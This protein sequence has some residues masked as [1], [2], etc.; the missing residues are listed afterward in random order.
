VI[1]A[2]LRKLR[3]AA[4][5]RAFVSG[6]PA[7]FEAQLGKAKEIVRVRR[8]GP[9]CD[10][11]QAFYTRLAQLERDAD[12]LRAAINGGGILWICYPKGK[13]LGTDLDR[14]VIRRAMAEHGLEAVA[15][16]AI[17]EVWSALRCKAS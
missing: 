15:I 6:A 10:V 12:R 9:S 14:D 3:F 16:V 13:A 1:S 8:L 5:A 2:T 17:D 7:A 4:G 11:V